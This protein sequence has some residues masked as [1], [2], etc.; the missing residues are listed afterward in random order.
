MQIYSFTSLNILFTPVFMRRSDSGLQ[1]KTQPYLLT[2]TLYNIAASVLLSFRHFQDPI[3][4]WFL[5]SC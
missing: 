1:Q 4:L 3:I 2:Y 5:Y